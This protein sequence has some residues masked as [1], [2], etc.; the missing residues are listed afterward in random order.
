MTHWGAVVPNK[1]KFSFMHL[2]AYVVL[3]KLLTIFFSMV[4]IQTTENSVSFLHTV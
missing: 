2:N 4:H 1:R 3:Y